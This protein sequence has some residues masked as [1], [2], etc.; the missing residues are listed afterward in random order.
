MIRHAPLFSTYSCLRQYIP[1]HYNVC[2][3][4]ISTPR[5]ETLLQSQ[6]ER[7]VYH[8][9]SGFSGPLKNRK[10]LFKE[11]TNSI[12]NNNSNSS[13]SETQG[14]SSQQP[15]RSGSGTRGGGRGGRSGGESGGGRTARGVSIGSSSIASH[16]SQFSTGGGGGAGGKRN[17]GNK[18]PANQNA[19]RRETSWGV[20]SDGERV[21]LDAGARSNVTNAAFRANKTNS[22]AMERRHHSVK[23]HFDIGPGME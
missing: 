17:S 23:S 16:H 12:N 20:D 15:K 8:L 7:P 21:V 22:N 4:K 5:F 18:N 14:G 3:I 6:E 10:Q 2:K 11:D 13:I 9:L 1:I 19:S